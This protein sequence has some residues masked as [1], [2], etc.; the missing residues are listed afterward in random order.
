MLNELNEKEK[1]VK[2]KSILVLS[3]PN[4]YSFQW[5]RAEFAVTEKTEAHQPCRAQTQIVSPA[6]DTNRPINTIFSYGYAFF[7]F[8]IDLKGKIQ[9]E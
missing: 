2:F 1:S 6:F 9:R 5:N 4:K 3:I 8:G 7:S